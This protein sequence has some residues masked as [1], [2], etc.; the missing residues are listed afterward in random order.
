MTAIVIAVIVAVVL[1]Y[2][3]CVVLLCNDVN[4]T[5]SNTVRLMAKRTPVI[6]FLAGLVCGHFFWPTTGFKDR[7]TDGQ[8]ACVGKADK[9]RPSGVSLCED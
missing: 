7:E 5:I 4:A 8:V 1:L 6:A 3:L 2:D 9:A